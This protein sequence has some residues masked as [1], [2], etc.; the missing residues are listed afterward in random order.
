M[1]S[2]KWTDPSIKVGITKIFVNGLESILWMDTT[3]NRINI[4][5]DE[6]CPYYGQI[7]FKVE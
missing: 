1:K 6:N 3:S 5:K 7:R 2:I 4:L